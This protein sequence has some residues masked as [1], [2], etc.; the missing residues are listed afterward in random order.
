MLRFVIGQLRHRAGRAVALGVGILV[1]ASSFMVLTA[2]AKTSSIRVKGSV[3]SNFRTA[4][5]ILVRPAG[6]ATPLEQSERLVRPNY[7]AGVFGGITLAE[8]QTI[9]RIRGVAVAA[10]IANLGYFLPQGNLPVDI[11]NLVN[12]DPVQLYRVRYTWVAD[13]G[14][15]RY[16]GGDQYVYY[17]RRDRFVLGHGFTPGGEIVPGRSKPLQVCRLFGAS[18]P[19]AD[20]P[21]DPLNGTYLNCFSARSPEIAAEN[22][23]SNLGL[24]PGAIGTAE[25][26]LF[27]ILVAAIDPVEEAKLLH[28]PRT[29]VSGRYL[30]E[31][32]APYVH[33]TSTGYGHLLVPAIAASRTY[34]GDRVDVTVQ[35]LGGFNPQ[36]LPE[37]LASGHGYQ[38]ASHLPGSV[39]ARRTVGFRT[40]YEQLLRGQPGQAPG[41]LSSPIYWTVSPV[42]YRRLAADQLAPRSVPD[43]PN[44]WRSPFYQS[45]SGQGGFLPAPAASRDVQFRA[46]QRHSRSNF[47]AGKVLKGASFQVVGRY[48]PA[49]L[50]GF[51]PLSRVP[52]ET[53]YPP[54]LAPNDSRTA[55]LLDG[56]PLLPSENVGGYIQQPP[57]MLISLAGLK[58]F[59]NSGFYSGVSAKAPIGVIRVRVAG[60]AGPDA[61]SMARIRSVAIAIHDRTGLK[62]DITAGS[63]PHPVAI[64]LPKGK[65]GRPQ[66]DLREGWS[67][68]GVSTAFLKA[69]DSKDVGL[70][71]LILAVCALY[72][73]N[74]SA[75]AVRTRRTEI[76]TL[77]T[78]AWRPRDIFA[79]VLGELLLIGTAAGAL[80][81]L[82]SGAVV[83]AFDL[84]MPLWQIALVLPLAL[85]LALTAGL[86]PAWLASARVPLDAVRP[87]I[88]G[89]ERSGHAG[90]LVALALVNLR[91]VPARTAVAASSLFLGVAALTLLIGIE[92]SFQGSLVGTLLGDAISIRVNRFDFAAVGVTVALGTLAIAD[93]TYLNLRQR[94]VELVTLR[95][96]GW[97]E[98]DLSLLI[99]LESVGIGLIGGGAGALVGLGLGLVLGLPVGTLAAA[100]A[101]G[102]AG[103]LLVALIG[104]LAPLSQL[105]R[106][107]AP[108]VLAAE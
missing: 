1:A 40:S 59:L 84:S 30:R 49:G 27:P 15:S 22:I 9:K 73:A 70:F 105:H 96:V 107:N 88:S 36:T 38:L 77:L 45:S 12:K 99:A 11:T 69:V 90:N 93:V 68:K 98:R 4:Y 47:F 28:L 20:G 79:A 3:E 72:V 104:S 67:K 43:D 66:L 10:P 74:G 64:E 13:N 25:I 34:V 60:V 21:F 50:P 41:E 89:K 87:A 92:R 57:L 16:S 44:D 102:L 48:D 54:Q 65:F 7:L 97:G 14:L 37:Q 19:T 29:I 71:S 100:A 52:L 24:P 23:S 26:S 55:G 78:I 85:A 91:R 56:S 95:T 17:N 35:R 46:L 61:L 76:G 31:N 33:Q 18:Q 6:A 94:S 106:L 62:V 83:R 63:S 108:V 39:I 103:A 75:A 80:G 8:Y 42:R 58:P 51:S 101:L 82:A 32:D 5:D 2:T 86:V 53:Y 81:V